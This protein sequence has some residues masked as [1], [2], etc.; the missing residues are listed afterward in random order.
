MR[1]DTLRQK[2]SVANKKKLLYSHMLLFNSSS[3][4]G[5]ESNSSVTIFFV[6]YKELDDIP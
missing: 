1:K 3:K 4:I 2:L 6:R 5:V